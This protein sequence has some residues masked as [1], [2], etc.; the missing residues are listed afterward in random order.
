M[1][2]KFPEKLEFLFEPSRYKVLHG[3]RGGSKSWGI[4]RAALIT[5]AQQPLQWLCTRELQKSIRE[6]V[7]RLLAD[8]IN[9]LGLNWLYTVHNTSIVGRNGTEFAFE[10]LRH[11]AAEI[12]SYEGFDRAWVEEAHAV[13][14]SSWDLLIPTIRKD[15]SE[16]WISFNPE[17]E[18]DETYERF[19][20]NPPASAR[21]VEVNWRD[22]PWFPAVLEEE[23]LELKAK[24]PDSYDHVW[25]GKCRR[26]LEGAIYARELRAAYDGGRVREVTH[27]PSVPVF[28]GWDIG[29][30][31]DTAIWWFQVVG[32]EIHL[33]EAMSEPG[34]DPAYFAS[35]ILGRRV[36]I[37]IIDGELK[38]EVGDPIEELAHRQA[39]EYRTHWL[40]PDAKAK[41]FAAYGKS[42][43]EQLRAALGHGS[44]D[45]IPVLRREDG[46]KAARSM[47]PRCYFDR[48]RCADGLKGLRRYRR[49]MQ[50]DGVSLQLSPKHDWA[51]NPADAFRSVA[52][53]W[54]SRRPPKDPPPPIRDTWGRT[55]ET[56]SWKTL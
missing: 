55:M 7:H 25:E 56:D 40:P 27:D 44:V 34:H 26:W 11:N 46:I 31:D 23:R 29:R 5:G 48:A 4:A 15:G 35:Q 37:D 8:Q 52:V 12:K 22:N 3:G 9:A 19:V 43:E 38:V 53:A 54:E 10:G 42:T 28:S 6:S 20:L 50:T 1:R 24:D 41:T 16:I 17:F 32:N 49:E 14:K 39:Y 13:S 21:V 30:T 47:F 45:I 18:D 33:I 51:S 36:Q 2:A